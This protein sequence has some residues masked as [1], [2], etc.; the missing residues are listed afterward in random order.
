MMIRS[1]VGVIRSVVEGRVLVK[2]ALCV[3]V[4]GSERRSYGVKLAARAL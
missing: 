4:M 1:V 3:V 2:Y